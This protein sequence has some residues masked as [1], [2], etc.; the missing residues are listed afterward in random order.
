M[1]RAWVEQLAANR[2]GVFIGARR[3]GFIDVDGPLHVA[4]RGD[5]YETAVEVDRAIRFDQALR[6]LLAA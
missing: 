5:D 3:V 1:S 4:L 2:Y 6:A